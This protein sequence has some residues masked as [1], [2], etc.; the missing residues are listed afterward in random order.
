MEETLLDKG[1]I[2]KTKKRKEGL[3]LMYSRQQAKAL[4]T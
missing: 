4:S 1:I 2:E 3:G